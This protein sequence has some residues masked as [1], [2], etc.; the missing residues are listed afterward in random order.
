MKKIIGFIGKQG[1]GKDTCT[2]YLCEKH[3]A[4][5]LKFSTIMADCLIRLGLPVV[6]DNLIAFSKVTRAAF[7]QDL[8]AK[9]IAKDAANTADLVAINGI[10]RSGDISALKNMPEFTLIA[11]DAPP[12]L[13]YER[14]LNRRERADDK[15]LTWEKF[16][17]VEDDETESTIPEVMAQ[18]NITI[19]NSGTLNQLKSKIDEIVTGF[20]RG[21]HDE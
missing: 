20:D 6:R 17:A 2:D 5:V 11:I 1:S 9:A 15:N 13:R 18:A 21:H 16:Q 4:K 10:R 3:G 8:Y 7:G 12:K 14:I 19:D